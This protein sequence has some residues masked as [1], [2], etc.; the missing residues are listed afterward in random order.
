MS[1]RTIPV[2]GVPFERPAEHNG[3]P[4][5]AEEERKHKE[6]LDKLKRETPEQ[7]TEATQSDLQ[8]EDSRRCLLSISL[9]QQ[10]SGNRPEWVLPRMLAPFFGE[11]EEH[12]AAS[13]ASRKA[14]VLAEWRGAGRFPRLDSPS[15][16]RVSGAFTQ[17]QRQDALLPHRRQLPR[18]CT[19]AM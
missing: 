19:L 11:P 7:R 16:N 5:S 3:R 18:G 2:N 4:P 9:R 8:P 17:Y 10:R 14:Q 12:G 1:S 13:Q 6:R 15:P